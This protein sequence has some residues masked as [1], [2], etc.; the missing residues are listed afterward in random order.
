MPHLPTLL[1]YGL[2]ADSTAVLLDFLARPTFHGLRPDLSDLI[3]ATAM[4]G[5]EWDDTI[6]DVERHILP[7]LRRAGV[8]YVQLA[9]GGPRDA[10]GILVLDDSRAPTRLYPAGPWRLSDELTAAGT[11]PM[12]ANGHRTCSLKFKGWPLDK[13]AGQE[14]GARPYRRAIG[15]NADERGRAEK[16]RRLTAQARTACTPIYPL[17]EMG[18]GRA[19][20][21]QI[22]HERLGVILNKSYCAQCPF[23][24]VAASRERHEARLRRFPEH[25][26]QVLAME[27]TAMALNENSSLYATASLYG[28]L[29][30]DPANAVILDKFDAHLDA[31]DWAVYDVRR[32]YN[33][34]RTPGCRAEHGP[35]CRTPAPGCRDEH[36]KGPAWRAVTTLYTGP[37][38][39][40]ELL[41]RKV[42][43]KHQAPLRRGETSSIARAHYLEHIAD[44]Y[45]AAHGCIVAAPAGAK[46][47][48]RPGFA[49][50]WRQITGGVGLP[51]R[52]REAA[53]NA[54]S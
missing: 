45:P 42:A 24:G 40:A 44:T 10:D 26:V 47:K 33:A 53:H 7:R 50:R 19:R 52:P 15:Y 13:W 29:A 54:S 30:E 38:D 22:L 43:H 31:V 20:V 46:D 14:F 36:A 11:V 12:V 49:R 28:R 35:T 16:D 3:V 1:T 25:A 23:S 48:Q 9:R 6:A 37:R 41:V 18:W 17:I 32:I 27:Y 4:T 34:K 39:T 8:R 51:Y 5:D 2:G 21:E